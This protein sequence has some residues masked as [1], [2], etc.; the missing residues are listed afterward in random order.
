MTQ[1]PSSPRVLVIGLDGATYDVLMPLAAAGVMPN[2]ATLLTRAALVDCQSTQ[3]AITPVAWTTVLTGAQPEEHGILDYRYLDAESGALRLNQARRVRVPNLFDAVGRSGDVVSINVPMTYPAPSNLGGLIVGG[4]DSPST[5]AVLEPY[6]EF[7]RRLRASGAWYG[8][9]TIWK[10]KPESFAELSQNVTATQADFRGRV[11]AAK[12][13]DKL[14]D[15]RLMLV[16]FQTLDSLQHR[17]WH[18]LG[19]ESAPGGHPEWIARLREA[20]RTLDDCLGELIELA[21]R[22]R[23]ALVIASDHG[24]GPF[25]EKISLAELLRQRDLVVRADAPRHVAHWLWRK[26]WR[27]RR[28]L[29]RRWQP[30]RSTANIERPLASLAPIDWARSRAV[31]LHGN[32]AGLVYLNTAARFGAGPISTADQ[33]DGALAETMAAFREARHPETGEP[34]FV[35]VF[36][37]RERLGCDPLECS[38]PDV[39]AI[40]ADGF[41]TRPKFDRAWRLMVPDPKLTGTHRA[42][43]VLMIDAPGVQPG[44]SCRANLRD[45]APTLLQM[46]GGST[47]ASMSG[48][49]LGELWGRGDMV[50]PSTARTGAR[51]SSPSPSRFVV[52][53]Q[54]SPQAQ[55]T[56]EA[57][58]RELGYIE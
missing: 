42:A 35:D 28:S 37:T 14:H 2:L 10:R 21:A 38:W 13:A 57:R 12:I 31:A 53:G 40:P 20:L 33:Y 29:A 47:P 24:F 5:A 7:A 39:V 49:V 16:Q 8:L 46:L 30:G 11:A 18:L 25:R 1:I 50:P 36:A 3:P 6:P 44:D 55:A 27:W 9:E 4:L 51:H 19:L 54:P 32:L 15:W 56:V 45:V 48:R 41:H 52:A 23:A 17:C 43:G 34:L 22:R 58:L 26:T